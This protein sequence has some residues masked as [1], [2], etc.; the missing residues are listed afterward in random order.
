MADQESQGRGRRQQV[1][2]RVMNLPGQQAQG[3]AVLLGL[4][5][6]GADLF[7]ALFRPVLAQPF[8]P[9]VQTLKGFVRVHGVPMNGFLFLGHGVQLLGQFFIPLRG[10]I[11]A[12]VF[13]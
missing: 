10:R 9:G 4:Q 7:Q 6:I 1:D 3:A 5:R 8:L 12:G 2:Q 13:G 11:G